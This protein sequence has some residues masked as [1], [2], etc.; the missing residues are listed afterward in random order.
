M[1]EVM[2]ALSILVVCMVVLMEIQVLATDNTAE[3]QR[4]ITATQLAQEKLTEVRLL[5]EHEGF[6]D[7][8]LN[9]HGDFD[10]WGD[11]ALNIEMD[12][13][14][15]F[16]W[17]YLVTKTELGAGSDLTSLVGN[18]TSSFSD[19]QD[20]AAA[21]PDLSA[22]G[23]SP[24]FLQNMI[25]P[26]IREVRIRVYWGDDQDE[27]EEDGREVVLTSYVINPQGDI[28]GRSGLRGGAPAI[29][30][31][32]GGQRLPPG[33]APRGVPGGVQGRGIPSSP[34]TPTVGGGRR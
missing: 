33:A 7:A 23:I 34:R 21:A 29:P 3:A 2:I 18:L 9:D 5:V 22:L 6:P 4:I 19:G 16:H 15:D 32:G 24:E 8:D 26:F 14:D 31:A 27:A 1:L 10:D 17:E 28:L 25:E 30:G 20:A 11:D 12:E 13:L